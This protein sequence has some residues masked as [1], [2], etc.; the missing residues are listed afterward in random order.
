MKLNNNQK[1]IAQMQGLMMVKILSAVFDS[2]NG[3]IVID[4]ETFDKAE[5][6]FY[7]ASEE[8]GNKIILRKTNGKSKIYDDFLKGMN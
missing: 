8:K 3:E 5:M 4:K 6:K 7:V 2:Q 1:E